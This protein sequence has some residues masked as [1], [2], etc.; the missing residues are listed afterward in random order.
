MKGT[1]KKTKLCWNCDGVVER[2]TENC[3]YCGVYLHPDQETHDDSDDEESESLPE[4]KPIYS[5]EGAQE[6]APRRQTAPK[7]HHED[8]KGILFSFLFLLTGS[9]F[10]LFSFILYFFAKDGVF[11]LRWNAEYWY[12]YLLVALPLLFAGWKALH[13]FEE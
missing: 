12:I 11:V 1:S 5:K 4:H 3:I 2:S 13:Y 6:E 9:F 10:L 7:A 8:P